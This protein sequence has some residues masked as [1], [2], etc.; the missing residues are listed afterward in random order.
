MLGI[1][2]SF[3]STTLLPESPKVILSNVFM[4]ARACHTDSYQHNDDNQR[5]FRSL[6][7]C[8]CEN[9]GSIV[10]V[11]RFSVAQAAALPSSW[12][13]SIAFVIILPTESG[14]ASILFLKTARAS[15]RS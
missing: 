7:R 15:D 5:V 8:S 13:H 6:R 14:A 1:F 4:C 3:P 12:G 10:A 2:H 11:L 9:F